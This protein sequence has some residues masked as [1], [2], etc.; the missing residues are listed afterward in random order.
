[1]SSKTKEFGGISSSNLVT[2]IV[3]DNDFEVDR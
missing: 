1:V 2:D 3:E